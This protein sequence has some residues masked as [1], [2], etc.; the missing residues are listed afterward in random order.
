V[1]AIEIAVAPVSMGGDVG[2]AAG[3][4]LQALVKNANAEKITVS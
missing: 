3:V 1:D 2:S 4:A